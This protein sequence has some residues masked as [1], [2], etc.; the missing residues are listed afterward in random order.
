MKKTGLLI[1]IISTLLFTSL[2]CAQEG[3]TLKGRITNAQT[4][5]GL[6][7]AEIVLEGTTLG[8][9]SDHNGFF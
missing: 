8:T 6:A 5:K 4:G 2:L 3:H 9:T 1:M 7:G